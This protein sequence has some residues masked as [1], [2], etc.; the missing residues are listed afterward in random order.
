MTTYTI[1]AQDAN[2]FWHDDIIVE[3]LAHDVYM[4]AV[5]IEAQSIWVDSDD[6]STH[7]ALCA[8]VLNQASGKPAT[9]PSVSSMTEDLNEWYAW[10]DT[11]WY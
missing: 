8:W 4:A 9:E 7:E 11:E 2:G 5:G 10:F 1:A 3:G 6:I